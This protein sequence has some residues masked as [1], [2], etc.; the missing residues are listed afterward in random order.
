MPA[1]Y[2]I[3]NKNGTVYVEANGVLTVDELI[4]T[5][6]KIISDPAIEKGFNTFADFSNAKVSSKVNYE[7]L[8]LSKEFVESIQDKRGKCKWAIY[9]PGNYEYA[10]STM[11]AVISKDLIIDTNVFK[12]KSEALDWLNTTSQI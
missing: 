11:Y 5:E 9:A 1:K 12:D 7:D 2:K 6:K 3:D 4:E 8:Q 10:F